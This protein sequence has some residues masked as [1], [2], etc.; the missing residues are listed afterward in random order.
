MTPPVSDPTA[1]NILEILRY[2]IPRLPPLEAFR[3]I[4][5][6]WS[7]ALRDLIFPQYSLW[8]VQPARVESRQP[9]PR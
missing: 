9:K 2:T 4:T 5:R 1:R 7:P 3:R 6:R 8:T